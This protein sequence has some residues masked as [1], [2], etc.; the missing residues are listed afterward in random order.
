[1]QMALLPF[2]WSMFQEDAGSGG[3]QDNSKDDDKQDDKDDAGKTYTQEQFRT[4]VAESV[5]NATANL[6]ETI[7][8]RVKQQ[9]EDD[10]KK[11]SDEEAAA[12]LKEDGKWQEL[13][14]QRQ[15]TITDLEK[16]IAELKGSKETADGA[17]TT[18]QKYFDFEFKRLPDRQQKLLKPLFDKMSVQDKLDYLVENH[19]DLFESEEDSQKG[20]RP[21]GN[22]N[23]SNQQQGNKSAATSYIHGT[24]VQA[25]SQQ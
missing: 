21:S 25:K 12:K 20:I 23:G 22:K 2:L 13:A 18:L 8:A 16:Q 19:D 24:Y 7:T 11:K 6:T 9:F 3:Q 15:T 4:A 1:M 17:T 5:R 14:D 10:A